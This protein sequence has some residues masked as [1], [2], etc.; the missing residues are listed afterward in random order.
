[1]DW[2]L[3]LP[4]ILVIVVYVAAFVMEKPWLRIT[5]IALLLFG[6]WL[7]DDGVYSYARNNGPD[8]VMEFFNATQ[9]YVHIILLLILALCIRGFRQSKLKLRSEAKF[10]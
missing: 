5:A 8:K 10:S 6:I 9:I 1:M 3:V 2:T 4:I 7:K